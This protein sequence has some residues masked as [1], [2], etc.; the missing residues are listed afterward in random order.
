MNAR[1]SRR[2]VRSFE[3][4][5]GKADGEGRMGKGG[6]GEVADDLGSGTGGGQHGTNALRGLVPL[7]VRQD[8]T[9]VT[10]GMIPRGVIGVAF[11][12]VP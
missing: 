9:E 1:L 12:L 10:N 5:S 7:R 4:V 2:H 3:D 11:C 8:A 6:V